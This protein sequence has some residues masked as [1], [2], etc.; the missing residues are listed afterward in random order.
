MA[1]RYK[2]MKKSYA[3]G[4]VGSNFSDGYSRGED[5][6]RA[7]ER[8]MGSMINEDRSAIANLPQQVVYKEYSKN[9][10]Q[11]YNLDDTITGINNQ[12]GHDIMMS[13]RLRAKSMY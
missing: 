11:G 3:S 13:K 10:Y 9:D 8:K 7:M 2:Q 6:G 5:P 1:K 4:G 12:I